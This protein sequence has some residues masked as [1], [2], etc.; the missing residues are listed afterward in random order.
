MLKKIIALTVS[1]FSATLCFAG[2]PTLQMTVGGSPNDLAISAGATLPVVGTATSA[3]GALSEHW[4]EIQNPEGAW[5]WE[6]WLTVEPWLG[7]LVGTSS[8]STK[9]GSFTFDENGTYAL[10]TTVLDSQGNWSI[11][12][13]VHVFVTSASTTTGHTLGPV[14][15]AFGDAGFETVSVGAN[16]FTAFAY[17]PSGSAWTFTG[18]AGV[19]GNNSGFTWGNGNA[20]EGK[21]VGFIQMGGGL[22]QAVPFAAGSYTISAQIAQRGQWQQQAQTVLVYV[23]GKQVGSFSASSAAY[24]TAT[25]SVFTV[26]A[27]VHD[28]RFIGQAAQDGTLFLDALTITSVPD[29]GTTPP[30]TTTSGGGTL[31]V[32]TTGS[33]I[34]N[35]D[36]SLNAAAYK[37][38]Y[39]IW[40]RNSVS[41]LL[42]PTFESLNPSAVDDRPTNFQPTPKTCSSS[43]VNRIN[44]YE[45]GPAGGCSPDSDYWSE[46]GQVAYVPD[47]P[48]DPGLD[49]VQTFAY[50]NNVFALSPRLDWAS[51]TPHPDPQ[52]QEWY[53]HQMLGFYPTQPV[54]MVRDYAMLQN[55]ALVVYR[56][57][58]LGVAGTQ[59][60][61]DSSERPYPGLIFPAN[62]IPTGIA[63]TASNEF[64]L[65][66][67]W[68]TQA[69]KGQLAVVALEGKYIPFHTW[70]YMGMPNQGSW[71]DFKL[72]GYID[73]P[74]YAP[75]SVSAASNGWWGGPSQTNNLVLSQINLTDDGVRLGL[76]AGDP[77]WS[78]VVAS[79][80]YAIVASK[81]E[82]KAVI[83]DLTPLF[84]YVRNSY[85]SSASSFQNTIN[86]RGDGPGQWPLT[87]AE[88]PEIK[89]AVVWQAN[90]QTPSAVLAGLKL[91][92]W[93]SDRQKAYIACEDG[94]IHIVD[95]SPLMARFDWETV[96]TLGEMGTCKVGR[97]PVCM[98]FT[99]HLDYSLPL[100]PVNSNGVQ[101]QADP[102]NNTFYVACRGDREVDAVV[103][104][105][106]N[107]T[108]YRR[109]RDSRMGDPVAVSV[110]GRGNIVSVTDF[111][112]KKLLS[113]RVGGIWDRYGRYYG[114]GADGTADFEFAGQISFGGCPIAVNTA[115]VN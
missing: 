109:I 69:L 41:A 63:V 3:D 34:F 44:P 95:T 21:Q 24:E 16:T 93:S 89:P 113:F 106:G 48:N 59:T 90:V 2:W 99:R 81:L 37:S 29:Q 104:Y 11:S 87:F 71:S 42:G 74:M 49:R 40:T 33:T 14:V 18:S 43:F 4:L 55:E 70:P 5:S 51:S 98:A 66:T 115:N 57:G 47:D 17:G 8:S 7:G 96:G 19:T 86:T 80:G 85:L 97:N 91:D 25:S 54:A 65:V 62:K 107:G 73:L 39:D 75:S 60:S 6:G 79:K 114:P 64:A 50:Y 78:G 56:D 35:A 28:L 61:R 111:N 112:G 105:G 68:D 67:V 27:G 15:A 72:L 46:T 53:Y 102:L 83:V 110:A 23:D 12:N 45:L 82:N 101:V 26:A 76:Y 38:F 84:T 92:R 77:Q 52:T 31:P 1:L 32:T 9:T 30:A 36:G 20:P 58:L 103:T 13:V 88:K 100:L 108:V 22:R 10:R 94:T